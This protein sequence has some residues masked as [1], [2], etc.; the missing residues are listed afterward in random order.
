MNGLAVAGAFVGG[1]ALYPPAIVTLRRLGLRQVERT[2]GPAS[3]L[4]KA[5]TPT[6]GGLVFCLILAAI[7]GLALRDPAGGV[8][9]AAAAL[10]AGVGFADDW[11]KV[12]RG[13]GL[14]ALPKFGLLA[15]CSGLLGWALSASGAG[16][17]I[18]PGLGWRDL[19]AG[20]IALAAFAAL[21]SANAANLT[22][23]VDGLTAGVA[24]PAFAACGLAA[25]IQHRPELATTCFV[26]AA[27]L[28]AFLIFN[29]PQA[30]IFMG[31]AGSLAIGLM[32]AVTATE[33]GLLL[34]L[35]LLAVVFLA[36]ALSVMV[37]VGYFKLS[38]GHRLLRMS[39]LHHHLELGGMGEWGIDLRLWAT[40]LVA[41]ALVLAW[42]LWSGLGGMRP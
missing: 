38:H 31:D 30:R 28:L 19:G 13:S 32:L 3:H 15:V 37:Q 33:T 42:A 39:P 34:L 35:P 5:G 11:L 29:R 9:V 23:G 6:A 4:R 18:V 22:D 7:W 14:R 36:E 26:L 27:G 25:S 12:R 20:A 2:E 10:G 24:L 40:S 21:A 1:V 8:V 16:L 41:T 17:Q